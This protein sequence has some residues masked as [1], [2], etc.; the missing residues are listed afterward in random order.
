MIFP[1]EFSKNNDSK[2]EQVVYNA[3]S[4]IYCQDSKVYVYHSV[5]I[6]NREF[7]R[8]ECEI[9]FVVLSEKYILCI[10]VKGGII[11]YN[12]KLGSWTQNG[13]Q[14]DDPIKQAVRNEHTFINRFRNDLKEI[15][16]Y[17]AV[18]F[19]DITL[20][21]SSLP[22]SALPHNI[23]DGQQLAYLP[24][25]FKSLE[26]HAYSLNRSDVF[27]GRN[28]KYSIKHINGVLSR[29]FHF[30]P[31]ILAK[32]AFDGQQ[33]AQLLEAQIN[34]V[35]AVSDNDRV[36]ITGPAGS[37][38]SL[39]G[40]HQLFERYES[41]DKVLFLTF[42]HALARNL[43]YQVVREYSFE[44]ESGLLITTFHSWAKRIIQEVDSG[45][46]DRST[47]DT[48]FWNFGIALK[49]VEVLPQLRVSY[50]FIVIDEAQDFEDVWLEPLELC[51]SK[52]GRIAA[53][54]DPEQD[55]FEK[56]NSFRALGFVNFRLTHVI[57]NSKKITEYISQECGLKLSPHE[58]C[59]EGLDIVDLRRS[60]NM[61]GDLS[62]KLKELGVETKSIVVLHDP[63]V[64]VALLKGASLGRDRI[65]PSRDGRARRGE[66]PYVSIK[67]FKG[68]EKEVVIIEGYDFIKE[69]SL[70]YVGLSRAQNILVLC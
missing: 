19:P 66:V 46:W 62:T 13:K 39:I 35:K 53:L 9:D 50:D 27:P 57:R 38:K 15:Q 20:G 48:E 29:G 14:L 23:I 49:L 4:R 54:I 67:Q 45:W 24:E 17:W 68:L 58:K 18:C 6:A 8:S 34:A 51:L 55:I 22:V 64:G 43:S 44:D 5:V 10:E 47:K 12:A 1:I 11:E 16:V 61:V 36:L 7:R 63:L 30:E 65:V 26:K 52:D 31:S 25:Y 33:Y 60:L 2:A 37:G 70:K 32:L 56:S 21:G 59:P 3:L 40:L 42:N 41:G 69:E 28:A